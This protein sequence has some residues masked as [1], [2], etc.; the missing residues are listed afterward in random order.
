MKNITCPR[1]D[2][3]TDEWMECV[4]CEVRFCDKCLRRHHCSHGY[5]TEE[6]QCMDCGKYF[7]PEEVTEISGDKYC[8]TCFEKHKSNE[9]KGD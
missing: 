7:A 6:F 3:T 9:S 8:S 5:S 2:K 4:Y 1:C